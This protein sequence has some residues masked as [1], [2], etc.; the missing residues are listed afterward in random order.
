MPS[1]R[2]P[3]IARDSPVSFLR[4]IGVCQEPHAVI[5]TAEGSACGHDPG[6]YPSPGEAIRSN[7]SGNPSATSLRFRGF[8]RLG[9][10]LPAL[11]QDHLRCGEE[12]LGILDGRVYLVEQQQDVQPP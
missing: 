4:P 6:P 1:F 10:I 3:A 8:R 9:G 12:Q 11:L 5:T 2:L 7:G